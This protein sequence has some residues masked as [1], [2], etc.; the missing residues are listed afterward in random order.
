MNLLHL[1]NLKNFFINHAEGGY[2]PVY[3]SFDEDDESNLLKV[4]QMDM[5]C[6]WRLEDGKI[7]FLEVS[8]ETKEQL[9]EIIAYLKACL[10]YL[11]GSII[12]NIE[13]LEVSGEELMNV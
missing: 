8:F 9:N 13:K 5:I 6:E 12:E 3:S 1:L 7:K 11:H 4:V 10:G 2:Y